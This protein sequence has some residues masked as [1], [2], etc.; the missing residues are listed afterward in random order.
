[1]SETQGFQQF[2]IVPAPRLAD[3]QSDE[4]DE[5]DELDW[6][7]EN[8]SEVV[9]QIRQPPDDSSYASEM[10]SKAKAVSHQDFGDVVMRGYRLYWKCV[11][12]SPACVHLLEVDL[13]EVTV[14]VR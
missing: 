4:G 1:L 14:S 9:R 6:M 8:T 7:M 11:S 3:I 13:E 12:L 2:N 5:S 10:T